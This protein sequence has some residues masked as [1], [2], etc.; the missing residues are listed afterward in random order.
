MWPLISYKFSDKK[1]YDF[2]LKLKW[3]FLEHYFQLFLTASKYLVLWDCFRTGSSFVQADH[4]VHMEN[5]SFS[6]CVIEAD[7]E[8]STGTIHG[9][10]LK[11]GWNPVRDIRLCMFNTISIKKS[12]KNYIISFG[13]KLS[14][15]KPCIWILIIHFFKGCPHCSNWNLLKEHG[16]QKICI[17]YIK[18]NQVITCIIGVKN[19]IAKIVFVLCHIKHKIFI[20]DK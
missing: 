8:L 19:P 14:F 7:N 12:R 15:I 3:K 13:N 10:F 2:D 4:S 6:I 11:S 18:R 17:R 16:S 1:L 20:R 9:E 5:F